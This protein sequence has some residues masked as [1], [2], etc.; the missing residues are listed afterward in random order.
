VVAVAD[1]T[2][3]YFEQYLAHTRLEHG[4]FFDLERLVC[5]NYDGGFESLGEICG[6][7]HVGLCDSKEVRR[8]STCL[9]GYFR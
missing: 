5:A 7:G 6:S 3:M 4:N 2:G 1:A 9:V 8:M